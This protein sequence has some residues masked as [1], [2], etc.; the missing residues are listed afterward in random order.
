MVLDLGVGQGGALHR[1]PHHGLGAA[2][3]LAGHQELVELADDLGFRAIVHGGVAT[4]PVAQHAQALELLALH[5]DPLGGVGAAAGAEL[6]LGDLVLAAALGAE[7]FLDLPLDRQA[8]AVP[9][10][11]VVHVLAE[12]ELRADHEVLQQLVQRMADVDGAVGVGRAVVQH[13]QRRAGVAAGLAHRAVQV[14]RNPALQDLRLELG[15]PGAHRELGLG[16]EHRVAIVARGGVGGG[17]LIVGHRGDMGREVWED[18]A[19]PYKRQS[20]IGDN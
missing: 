5:V 12:R 18:R 17:G 1:A 16:Q 20:R 6:G 10:G 3:E 13:E 14:F 9:A 2:I 7:L 19:P 11:H 8:V 15:Q 4:G